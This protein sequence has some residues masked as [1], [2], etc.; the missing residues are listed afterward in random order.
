MRTARALLALAPFALASLAPSTALAQ[1][2]R[3]SLR[4]EIGAGTMLHDFDHDSISAATPAIEV[5][6][7]LGFRLIGPFAVQAGAVYGRF[8][9]DRRAIA[10]VGGTLGAR[11]EPRIGSLGRFWVDA[12]AGVYLPG[13]VTRPGVE[14]GV[15]FDFEV[16][17]TLSV[18]PFARFTHVWE[19][20]E[21]RGT[22]ALPYAPQATRD[23][24]DIHW[25]TV[26]VTITIHLPAKGPSA[27]ERARDDHAPEASPAVPAPQTQTAA[28]R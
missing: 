27:F 10:V 6:P 4:A 16:L 8:L 20:R 11:F 12:N 9:R 22:L 7:R 15:G 26:G 3:W 24:D 18:G 21:G 19:G 17:S 28:P 13:T 25:W 5:S 14:A 2:R 1:A 23:T